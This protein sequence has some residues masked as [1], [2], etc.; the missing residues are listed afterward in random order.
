MPIPSQA[1]PTHATDQLMNRKCKHRYLIVE[2][3]MWPQT[4][5]K[6]TL[7]TSTAHI[8]WVAQCQ[9][10]SSILDRTECHPWWTCR[11]D[12]GAQVKKQQHSE[13]EPYRPKMSSDAN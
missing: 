3:R 6:R 7:Q 13:R 11:P 5:H 9:R 2:T 10:I 4:Q 1:P 12:S 8:S